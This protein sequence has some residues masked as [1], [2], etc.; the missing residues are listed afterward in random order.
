MRDPLESTGPFGISRKQKYFDNKQKL[1]NISWDQGE[2]VDLAYR[3]GNW[4]T[5]YL[6]HNHGEQSIYDFW[7]NVD[8]DS[9]DNTFIKVFGKDYRTYTDEF[10]VWLQQ[11]NSELY[12]IL[13]PIYDSKIKKA[14]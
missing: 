13:D 14:G 10:D 9:F 5:A 4:F 8:K 7:E 3:I 2:I 12:K 6:V 1:Y 11:S